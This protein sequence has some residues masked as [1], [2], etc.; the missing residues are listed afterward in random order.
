MLSAKIKA[1]EDS[2]VKSIS[3]LSLYSMILAI[4]TNMLF[5]R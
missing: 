1:R 5:M 3:L 2:L 4:L